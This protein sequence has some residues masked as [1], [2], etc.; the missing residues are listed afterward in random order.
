MSTVFSPATQMT[1]H[2]P[3]KDHAAASS[4]AAML[5]A[6]AVA[7]L[8]VVANQLMDAWVDGHLF[9]GWVTLWV[10]VF[11]GLGMLAGSARRIARRAVA[12]LDAW[13]RAQAQS[14]AQARGARLSAASRVPAKSSPV[15][16]DGASLRTVTRPD[17]DFTQALAPLGME[18]DL[19]SPAMLRRMAQTAMQRHSSYLPYL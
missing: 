17:E 15:R 3:V 19:A 9:L 13:S 16:T 14:R 7:A 1:G 12:A 4:L 2:K 10:V 5:L 6:A 11:G 18:A 8:A